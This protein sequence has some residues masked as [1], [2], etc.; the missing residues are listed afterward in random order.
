MVRYLNQRKILG[1]YNTKEDNYFVSRKVKFYEESS[2]DDD[3][4]VEVE[5]ENQ[6]NDSDRSSDN[7][8]PFHTDRLGDSSNSG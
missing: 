3:N 1:I 6:N 4:M 8:L 5:G 7:E 2:Y